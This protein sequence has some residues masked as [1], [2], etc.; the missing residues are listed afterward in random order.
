MRWVDALRFQILILTSCNFY[1]RKCW[2]YDPGVNSAFNFLGE[3]KGSGIG[4]Q[5]K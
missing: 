3:D 2:I 1:I 4:L 5:G